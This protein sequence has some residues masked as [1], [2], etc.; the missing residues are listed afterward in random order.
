[1]NER[2]ID[3]STLGMICIE[4]TPSP[5]CVPIPEFVK[6]LRTYTEMDCRNIVRQLADAIKT[7]HNAGIAHRNLNLENVIIDPLVSSENDSCC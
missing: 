1:V 2:R 7:M 5:E 3:E 6:D 4:E